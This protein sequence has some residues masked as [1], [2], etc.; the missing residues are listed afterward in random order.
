M[1]E[2][3]QK[4]SNMVY[5]IIDRFLI[6][7]QVQGQHPH[8]RALFHIAGLLH[9]WQIS[10]QIFHS[11]QSLSVSCFH[12]I[13]GLPG[14]RY[15]STCR[16]KAVLNAPL[17]RSTYPYQQGLLSFRMRSRSSM[18]S[19]ASSSLDLVVTVSCGLKLQICLVIALSFHCRCWK[20]G[21]VNG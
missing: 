18:P 11:L 1:Q 14:P 8:Q 12:V 2:S 20:F 9:V 3:K 21:F 13:F 15:P 4:T 7:M 5:I 6:N 10:H 19:R 16:S 17:E